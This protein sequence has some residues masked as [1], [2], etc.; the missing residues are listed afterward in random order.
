LWAL[1]GNWVES[2]I[3]GSQPAP[4]VGDD[5]SFTIHAASRFGSAALPF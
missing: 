5:E 4:Q 3:V 2:A 1:F